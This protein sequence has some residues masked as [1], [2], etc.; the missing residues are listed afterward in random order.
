MKEAATFWLSHF[1]SVVLILIW[2]N[3]IACL[4]KTQPNLKFVLLL[5]REKKWYPILGSTIEYKCVNPTSIRVIM[6][7]LLIGQFIHVRIT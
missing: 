5:E 7:S 1:L 4:H 2:R 6:T 3:T